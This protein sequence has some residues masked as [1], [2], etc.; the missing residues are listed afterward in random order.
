M[1]VMMIN[2]N[3]D[4]YDGCDDDDEY[5]WM[6][7]CSLAWCQISLGERLNKKE[8]KNYFLG[9]WVFAN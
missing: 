2:D 8:R 6:I 3:N 5:D 4:D 1:V 9:W 7:I